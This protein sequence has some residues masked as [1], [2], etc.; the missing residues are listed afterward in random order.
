MPKHT[1]GSA[2]EAQET[3][4]PTPDG[5]GAKRT[6]PAATAGAINGATAIARGRPVAERKKKYLVAPRAAVT[7]AF[8]TSSWVAPLG[9]TAVQQAL[10]ALPDI[11]VVDTI[12]T[13]GGMAPAGFSP[14][15]MGEPADGVVVA[16]MTDQKAGELLQ[17][18]QGQLLVERDQHLELLDPMLRRPDLVSSLTPYSG[19]QAEL[20]LAVVGKDGAPLPDVEV[21]LF[22][23]ALPSSAVTGP[24]GVAHLRLY[25]EDAH[26]ISGL[27]VK[28]R[29][30]YWSHYQRDPDL[31]LDEANVVMLRPLAD[32]PALRGMPQQPAMGW[33]ARAMRLDQVPQQFR[34]RG[35]KIAVIDSGAATTHGNLNQIHAGFDVVN[36]HVDRS[37]WN[38]D[39]LGHG[40]HCAGVI[41]AADP[42]WG[43][44][45]F[46]PEAEIHVCKLFP[47]GQ[48]SQL[49]D[50]L[51]YCIEQ[52]IDVVN[53][54][55]GGGSP[56][57]ALERQ[58][59]RAKQA[60]VA[61]IA[62]A[63]NSSSAVQY[64]AS[65]PHVLAVAAIGKI[66]EFPPDSYHAETLSPDSDMQGFF[67]AKFSCFGPQVDV[68]APGVAVVS[69]VPPNN[70]A[71]WDGTSM[72][73][74]HI[75][76]LAALVLAHRPEF[77][78]MSLPRSP[79]RV[80]RL[81]QVLRM[82]ARPV[83]LSDPNRIGYGLPDAL[84]ALGLPV[85]QPGMAW[86]AAAAG[87]G[88]PAG[89]FAGLPGDGTRL[90]M[91]PP[92]SGG[93]GQAGTMQYPFGGLRPSGW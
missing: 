63:G 67:T 31:S 81:F 65:S 74:P 5:A 48:V 34:G 64:P 8:G 87:F 60:G 45:G 19:P 14:A 91:G 68:C 21:S 88:I 29:T 9:L 3:T 23:G 93:A 44:R 1:K 57:E 85:A 59:V 92:G 66:G 56:S 30:D 6:A 33:G 46:A 39:T 16:R 22:G 50:A 82:S 77:Q 24:D 54:S 12:A 89:M 25:G 11:D 4:N 32:W 35:V 37:T 79:E 18:G 15:A 52:G 71:A 70:F 72:A 83:T 73:A 26:T 41:G 84:V 90:G 78:S 51:E 40:S 10:H 55:L 86:Q 36:K 61:C 80:E 13:R 43:I 76:G 58:I 69:S 20:L 28:P 2:G 42:A 62:A 38:V 75:T 27:Y 17:R 47:G 7:G 53:L 49:I